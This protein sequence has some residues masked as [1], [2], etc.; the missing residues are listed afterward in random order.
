MNDANAWWAKRADARARKARLRHQQRKV[1]Q[2]LNAGALNAYAAGAE[3]GLI[4]FAQF[5][6]YLGGAT[7]PMLLGCTTIIINETEGESD[8]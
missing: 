7:M 6:A 1:R 8:A 4:D 2:L 3:P 5:D